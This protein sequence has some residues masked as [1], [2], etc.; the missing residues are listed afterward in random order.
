MTSRE[1][2]HVIALI[3]EALQVQSTSK[4]RVGDISFRADLGR[5]RGKAAREMQ[6]ASLRE[7]GESTEFP[8]LEL[9]GNVALLHKV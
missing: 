3:D 8:P 7:R 1:Y 2:Q 4:D 5:N 6:K 9:R